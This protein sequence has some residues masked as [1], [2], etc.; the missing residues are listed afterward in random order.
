MP[1]SS[2]ANELGF[3]DELDFMSD[4]EKLELINIENLSLGTENKQEEQRIPS[5]IPKN[6][7]TNLLPAGCINDQV[8]LVYTGNLVAYPFR[9]LITGP[10]LN[11]LNKRIT[12]VKPSTRFRLRIPKS[13][14]YFINA[15]TNLFTTQRYK[16]ML[17]IRFI[18]AQPTEHLIIYKRGR[19]VREGAGVSAFYFSPFASLVRIPLA[20]VD[21]P[22]IFNEITADFQSVSI[23]GQITYRVQN[24]S[25]LAALLNY[26]LTY[27]GEDYATEDPQKLAQ[28]LV[29]HTQVLTSSVIKH[30][31]LREVLTVSSDL[32][33]KLRADLQANEAIRSLGLEVL[34]LAIL[35]IKPTPETARALEAEARESI[36]Q[37]ADEA[38]YARRNAAVEQ[39]RAIKE[40]ELNTEIAVEQKKRQIRE[41]KMEAEK[42][43]QQK[44]RE[45]EEAKMQT[46][47]ALEEQNR[48]LVELSVSNARKEADAKAY[49]LTVAMQALQGVDFKVVQA[50]ASINM[51]SGQLIAQAFREIAQG[52]EKVGQ[53]NVSPELLSELLG[54]RSYHQ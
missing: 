24:P 3:L 10:R 11:L 32:V 30:L 23:Q 31:Q 7:N 4:L 44:E 8:N 34:A 51:D 42:A 2:K 39:E 43:V 1:S 20:S 36:L 16:S 27:N 6:I 12:S 15:I 37:R 49:A 46:R 54:K 33:T 29:N 35:A 22:F 52:A 18:K 9:R 28:R 50:L 47:I 19:I 14:P 45:L 25:Q 5:E 17:G 13:V 26:S 41:T 53:L 38:I 40:N 21:I 48:L